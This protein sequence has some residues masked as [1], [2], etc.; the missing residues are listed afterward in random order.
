MD[1]QRADSKFS[2]FVRAVRVLISWVIGPNH[3]QPEIGWHY[4]RASE[5]TILDLSSM[6]ASNRT[7]P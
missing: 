4:F 5:P 3:G 7:R 1:A 6:A 2:Q